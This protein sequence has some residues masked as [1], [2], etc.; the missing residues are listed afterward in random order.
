MIEIDEH[1]LA[2][3][4]RAVAPEPGHPALVRAVR[5]LLPALEISRLPIEDE[6]Y[7]LGGVVNEAGERVADDL[8]AW[9]EEESEG[10]VDILMA[11]YGEAKYFA[12]CLIGRTHYLL[13]PTGMG[14][15]DFLQIE[16]EEAEEMFDHPLFDGRSLPDNLE[17]VIDPLDC[18]H[19]SR[20]ALAPPRYALRRATLFAERVGELTSEFTGDPRFR[21]F[22]DEWGASS[23]GQAARFCDHWALTVFPYRD[24]FGDHKSEVKPLSPHAG[25][26]AGMERGDPQ[27]GAT[28]AESLHAID[29]E[30]GFPMAWY[31][32]M[33]TRNYLPYKVIHAIHD[34]FSGRDGGYAVLPERDL[35]ILEGWTRDPYHL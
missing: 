32:L 7:R 15:M 1:R 2:E 4:C 17:D 34:T 22:L 16:V 6:W 18:R 26:V 5:G 31:F 20:R 13:A 10:D 28:L 19:D 35:A 25:L 23:A 21:R 24:S 29:R 30:A 33:L 3:T 9:V 12:T 11:R 14:A 27:A 8:E